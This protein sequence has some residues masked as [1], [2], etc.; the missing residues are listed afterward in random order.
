[1]SDEEIA[2]E[3]VHKVSDLVE[4]LALHDDECAEHGFLGI[5]LVPGIG[6][7]QDKLYAAEELV[8]K[9]GDTL[10]CEQQHIP[11]DFLAVDRGQSLSV[12]FLGNSI[13]RYWLAAFYICLE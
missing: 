3:E 5:A 2:L 9:R 8:V 4:A 12:W 7:G 6:T 1:M 10:G 13:I 11:H